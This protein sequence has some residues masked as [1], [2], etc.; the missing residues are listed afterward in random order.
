MYCQHASCYGTLNCQQVGGLVMVINCQQPGCC[1]V[2]DTIRK[3]VDDCVMT[4]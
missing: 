2:Y 4:H 1:V 3:L